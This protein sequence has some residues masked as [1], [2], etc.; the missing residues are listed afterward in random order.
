MNEARAEKRKR[1]H[2]SL[3]ALCVFKHWC[4]DAMEKKNDFK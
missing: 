4:N 2:V 3:W 1:D